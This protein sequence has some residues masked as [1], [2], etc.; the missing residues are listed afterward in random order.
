[1]STGMELYSRGVII[2]PKLP[3]HSVQSEITQWTPQHWPSHLS[4]TLFLFHSEMCTKMLYKVQCCIHVPFFW[5]FV[6]L[7]P[8]WKPKDCAVHGSVCK[9]TGFTHTTDIC[10]W[11]EKSLKRDKPHTAQAIALHVRALQNS[12]KVKDRF[13]VFV[14]KWL[15]AR[16][17]R[18]TRQE[19]RK[20]NSWFCSLWTAS[21]GCLN[22]W[23]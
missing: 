7:N 2:H 22:F 21:N 18:C 19:G 4:L 11:N 5:V 15:Q 3:L 12:H 16:C 10:C 13:G 14:P 17:C 9:Q 6:V 8:S 23:C 1:M 20:G